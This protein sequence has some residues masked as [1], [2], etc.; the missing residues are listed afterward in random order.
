MLGDHRRRSLMRIEHFCPIS[1]HTLILEINA[2]AP[3]A[4]RTTSKTHFIVSMRHFHA[5]RAQIGGFIQHC[6]QLH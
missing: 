3:Y 5:F 6:G 2:K 1:Y 4:S